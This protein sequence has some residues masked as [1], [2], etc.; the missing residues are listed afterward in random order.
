[1][2]V[3]RPPHLEP[4]SG[5]PDAGV[6]Q[7]PTARQSPVPGAD[8][9]AD[10]S[11]TSAAAALADAVHIHPLDLSG[12]LQI[13]IAEVRAG[14]PLNGNPTPAVP[15]LPPGEA[16]PRPALESAAVRLEPLFTT[17]PQTLVQLFLQALPPPE[18]LEPAAWLASVVQLESAVQVALDRAVKAASVWRDV[19]AAVVDG[20]RETRDV[21]V[22]AITGEPPNPLWL[23]PEWLGLAPRMQEY[24]RR[25][26]RARRWLSDPD[27]QRPDRDANPV[28]KPPMD[29][30]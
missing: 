20:A 11:R 7:T 21:V 24:W 22:A 6:A 4:M 27:L 14:L 19:P 29:E 23:R 28:E 8:F 25:C 18:T 15:P 1:M 16:P 2:D 26:R 5:R 10:G 12:A 13:M 9:A 3:T 30:P 17:T